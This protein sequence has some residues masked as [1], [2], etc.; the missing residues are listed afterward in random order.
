M[1]ALQRIRQP[2]SAEEINELPLRRYTGPIH[3]VDD[4]AKVEPA[5][6]VLAKD[7]LL[8]FDTETKPSFTKGESHPPALLQLAT[9][10]DVYIFHLTHIGLPQPV[11][12]LL[13]DPA[14][15]KTGVA[16]TDDIKQLNR[17]TPFTPGGFMDLG[18][19]SRRHNLPTNGLR[20]LAANLLGFRIS[21]GPR[22][23]NWGL[24][25][26]S[27]KQVLYAATD[28][29]VGREIHLCMEEMGLMDNGDTA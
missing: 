17:L 24:A 3:L 13:A 6:E 18:D 2:I 5:L 16:V 22:N 7:P 1:N 8:G 21:K 4:P 9:A 28:A 14:V 29:W 26:L 11:A 20:N 15:I 12:D 10:S 23:S 25:T 19:L 27:R